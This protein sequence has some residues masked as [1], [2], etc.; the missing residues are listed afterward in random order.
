M[1]A[2]KDPMAEP[3]PEGDELRKSCTRPS[4]MTARVAR[5]RGVL[6]AGRNLL[7]LSLLDRPKEH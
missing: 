7:N 4:P 3:L 2:R 5:N 6:Y 1:E